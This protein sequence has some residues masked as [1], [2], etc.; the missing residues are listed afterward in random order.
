[1]SGMVDMDTDE[2][3][4]RVEWLEQEVKALRSGSAPS[5]PA[6]GVLTVAQEVGKIAV[7]NW[8]LISFVGAL[9]TAGYVK[10]KFGVDYFESYRNQATT[11]DLGEFYRLLGDRLMA[12]SEWAAAED[13]YR[14]ALQVHPNNAAAVYGVVKATVFQPSKGEKY[15]AGEVVDAKLDYLL[16][17]H[18]DAQIYFLKGVRSMGQG[19]L[20]E[21]ID[22]YE[23]AIAADS[24]FAGPY[25]NLGY[26]HMG[27]WDNAA[28]TRHVDLDKG[29]DAFEKALMLDPTLGMAHNNLGFVQL[30]AGNTAKAIEHLEKAYAIS[31]SLLTAINLGDAYRCAGKSDLA[32]AWHE[33]ALSNAIEI[34]TSDA[35]YLGLEWLYNYMP[36]APGDR[37]TI[38][39]FV[40]VYD[41][42]QKQAVA[43]YALSLDHAMVGQFS[44]ADSLFQ[45]AVE[46]E[47]T[48]AF[49]RFF[50]NKIQA[51]E[52]TVP[53]PPA[54]QL[55][56]QRH[57]GSLLGG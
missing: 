3:I 35:R 47:S 44:R 23:K 56:L 8:V 28:K 21:T 32:L 34:D 38:K 15:Y 11:R 14:Q 48:S 7:T 40:R 2:L 51:I 36:I 12:T 10:H 30:I 29:M 55:W 54:Q 45:R 42:K 37:E 4:R 57:R 13:A 6:S 39:K 27:F 18:P 33:T 41:R 53:L 50:A 52:K 19:Y 1:M 9:L 26:M 17:T 25:L 46:L 31:P 5:T 49:R 24:T 43:T 20:K 16:K 22:W